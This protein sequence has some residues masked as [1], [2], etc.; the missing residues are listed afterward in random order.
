L[1]VLLNGEEGAAPQ[2]SLCDIVAQVAQ[3]KR[4]QQQSGDALFDVRQQGSVA[5]E[6]VSYTDSDAVWL[7][8][9]AETSDEADEQQNIALNREDKANLNRIADHVE[10]ISKQ[11]K[12]EPSARPWF[13]IEQDVR[14]KLASVYDDQDSDY[15]RDLVYHTVKEVAQ[16]FGISE[17]RE[18]AKGE[19]KQ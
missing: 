15:I 12:D 14:N 18:Q 5:G 8:T 17:S 19:E 4:T 16:A 1:D 10:R 2:A 6:Y 9:L 13:D 11:A 7:R 3:Q